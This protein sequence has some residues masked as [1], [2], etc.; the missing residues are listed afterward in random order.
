[1]NIANTCE[2]L[3]FQQQSSTLTYV[4]SICDNE[5]LRVAISSTNVEANNQK[6]VLLNTIMT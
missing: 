4:G 5:I 3:T 6:G 1:M 2:I